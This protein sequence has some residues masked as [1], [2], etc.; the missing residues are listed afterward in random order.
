MGFFRNDFRFST[1]NARSAFGFDPQT[2]FE[3]GVARTAE[4]YKQHGDLS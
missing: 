4:W 3:E 1:R 2:S